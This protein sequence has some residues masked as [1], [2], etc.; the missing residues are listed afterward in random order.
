MTGTS[1]AVC[2]ACGRQAREDARFCDGC[3]SPIAA[4]PEAAEYKQVTVLFA[5]VVH[6]MDLAAAVGPERLREI[7]AELVDR[8]SAV[9]QRYGGTVDKFTGDGI[10][11]VFGAPVALEDHALRACRA[12]LGIQDEMSRLSVELQLRIGLN[13]GQVIAGEVGSKSL[14]YTTVG[15]QVGMAQR[16]ESAAPPGG[17]ML[18]EATARLVEDAAVLGEPEL[19]HIK[20]RDRP[21]HARRLL[22]VEARHGVVRPGEARLIGRQWEISAIEGVLRRA[23]KGHGAVVGVAGPPGIGKSRIARETAAMAQANGIKVSWTFG[24]SHAREIPFHVVD[25]LMRSAT[26]VEGLDAE[27]AR[28]EARSQFAGAD[29][30][31]LVLVYD[32][33]GIRA[34][35]IPMPTIDPDAR[36]RRLTALINGAFMARRDPAVYIIEDVHWIDEVSESMLA[37]FLAVV[38][39]TTSMVLITYRPDYQGRLSRVAG[40]QTISLAPFDDSESSALLT[41]LLGSDSSVA[42]LATEIGER[43]SGNPFFAEEIVRDL[44]E[45]GVL[46]GNRGAYACAANVADVSVPATLQAAITSRI[47]RLNSGAKRTL[48]AAAVIGSRFSADLLADLGVDSI[49]DELVTAQLIDQVSFTQ[50][51][52]YAF[53]H[54][55]IRTVAYEAQLKSDRAESHRRLAATIESRE[56]R[57]ADENA[58]L[59][60][61]HLEA[62]GDLRAA[63]AWRMRAG[64]WSHSRNIPAA[65]VS[66]ERAGQI[67]DGLPADDP[68]H[69]AMQIAPRTLWCANA[70]RAHIDISGD[71]FDELCELCAAAGDKASLAVAMSGLVAEHLNHGRLQ[72][73]SRVASENLALV[74]SIGDPA[75]TIG[76]SGIATAVKIEVG[77]MADILRLSQSVIDLAGDEG[78]KGDYIIGSPLAV[79]FASRCIARMG[80]GL[81]GWRDDLDRALAIARTADQT[82]RAVVITWTYGFALAAGCVL[83][84]DDAMRSIEDAVNTLEGAGDD[85]ALGLARITLGHALI[86]RDPPDF[87]RGL[88]MFANIRD[89]IERGLFHKTELAG[90]NLWIAFC[91]AKL[92]DRDGALRLLRESVDAMFDAGQFGYTVTATGVLAE[93]LLDRSADGDIDEAEKAVDRVAAEFPVDAGRAIVILRSR[94]LLAKARGDEATYRELVE[95]YRVTATSLGFEGHMAMAEAM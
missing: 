87:Q 34:P 44:T 93:M 86:H 71:R 12:A 5:D 43:A 59:I 20:N 51:V 15:E 16:M 37:D 18:S 6:S 72:E 21:V 89:M 91:M 35:D 29:E 83:V 46:V 41:E 79:A 68:D 53:R 32:Q 14:G 49:L 76:V 88:V 77:A 24:E 4:T 33:L 60:A 47:D 58:A 1:A 57:V 74:D 3:G 67:A 2:P 52:E 69:L 84:D 11:A 10:M 94:A 61:E 39:Q 54:P 56:P 62:A 38:P 13:S 36:R 65:L 30:E 70:F 7:M 80:L 63:Y 78:T 22:A 75:L 64:G 85:L 45:R 92:G 95:E 25:R 90:I 23:I 9:V 82:T 17:V 55:L 73:A 31:D 48:N 8:T 28:R 27:S 42:E 66:W 19:V 26:G 40:A 81:P 50:R